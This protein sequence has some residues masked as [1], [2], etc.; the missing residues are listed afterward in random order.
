MRFT[1]TSFQKRDRS[2][3]MVGFRMFSL[4]KMNREKLNFYRWGYFKMLFQKETRK[5]WARNKSVQQ[6]KILW[7]KLRMIMKIKT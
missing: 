2:D 1:Q 3:H 7:N 5:L 6:Q 4:T